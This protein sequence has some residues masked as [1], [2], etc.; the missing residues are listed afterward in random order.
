[1]SNIV[2]Y[3]SVP[4]I[5]YND[6][7]WFIFGAAVSV[8]ADLATLKADL[9]WGDGVYAGPVMTDKQFINLADGSKATWDGLIWTEFAGGVAA[10]MAADNPAEAP[11]D[12][13]I[14]QVQDFVGSDLVLAQQALDNEVP[15]LN[16]VTLV[17]WLEDLLGI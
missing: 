11:G 10:A 16:R 13:T 1:M 12:Y 2:G 14:V 3:E 7:T 8:F 15:G 5:L 4:P 17:A 9:T 6:Q